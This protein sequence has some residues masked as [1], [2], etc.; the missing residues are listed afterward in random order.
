[1]QLLPSWKGNLSVKEYNVIVEALAWQDMLDIRRYVSKTLMAPMAAK[2]IFL[3][4]KAA[5]YTL[6]DNPMRHAVIPDEPCKWLGIRRLAVENYE[7]FY[8]LDSKNKKVCVIRVLYN[9]REWQDLL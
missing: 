2:R 7:A 4:I 5:I 1:M 9:R 8:T 3:A 6:E